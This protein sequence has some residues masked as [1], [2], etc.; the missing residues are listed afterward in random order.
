[1]L[2]LL[3]ILKAISEILALSLIGQGILWLIA[4]RARESNF[5]YRLFAAVTRPLM[6]LTRAIMPRFVVDR[7]IWLVAVLLVIV[8]WFF[9][10]AYKL[11]RCLGEGRDSPL[12]GEIVQRIEERRSTP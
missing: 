7:H 10:A 12:C 5:V 3:S 4:G 1:M 9:S 11:Q 6:R 8:V 2:L